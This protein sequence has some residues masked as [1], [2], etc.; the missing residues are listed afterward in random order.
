MTKIKVEKILQH[1]KQN[2]EKMYCKNVVYI[3]YLKCLFIFSYKMRL[4]GSLWRRCGEVGEK[5]C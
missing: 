3:K 4:V 2:K 1:E 5:D